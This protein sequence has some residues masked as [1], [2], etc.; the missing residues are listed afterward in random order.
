ML[1]AITGKFRT[2]RSVAVKTDLFCI[3][4]ISESDQRYLEAIKDIEDEARPPFD[5]SAIRP[6]LDG[7]D[8]WLF[9]EQEH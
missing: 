3:I 9:E 1:S 6:N 4:M 2:K 8:A 7:D 5:R